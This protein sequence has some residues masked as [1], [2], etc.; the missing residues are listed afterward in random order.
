MQSL[1]SCGATDAQTLQLLDHAIDLHTSGAVEQ[2]AQI[3]RQVLMQDA[4]EPTAL[5]YLGIVLHQQGQNE[6]GIAYLRQS[7]DLQPDNAA[8]HND[9]GNVLFAT[10]QFAAAAQAYDMSLRFEPDDHEVWNNLGAAQL[11]GDD[12]AAAILSFQQALA[13][14]PD[15]VPALMHLGNIYEAAGDKLTSAGYQCRAY[16][17]PPLQGKSRE[18]LGISFYFLGRLQE[19]AEI[20]R[21]WM[22]EEP[23]NPIAAHMYAACSQTAVPGRASNN[24]I[25]Q[26]FDRYA[27]TFNAN[28][29]DSL[30]YRGPELMRQGLQQIAAAGA[31]YDILDLGCGTGLCAPIAAPYRRSL[32]GVDLSGKMLDQARARGGYDGLFKQEICAYM[33]TRKAAFDIVL[34]ADTVIYFGD[35]REVL[36]AVARSL[37]PG[38]HIIFTIEAVE[39]DEASGGPGFHL[40]A[41]GRYRHS[42]AYV[43]Q[44]LQNADLLLVSLSDAVLREEIR[45]PVAGM[46]V[47]ARRAD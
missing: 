45:R 25:E 31:Q 35:L 42:K 20:Y 17:L 36:N 10:Q 24:Y 22:D 38:G 32:I 3:Y 7:C 12:S 15:F 47:I 6:D 44:T 2:A 11:Q 21:L 18:M 8:W 34:A 26:Y 23:D 5:H 16:V 39:P 19:A 33:D 28:L 37:R 13:L 41:S 43:S 4:Q 14:L 30:A 1:S 29:T 9:L 27:D 46:L 40:H